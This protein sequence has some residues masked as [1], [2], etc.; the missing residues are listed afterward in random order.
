MQNIEQKE[1]D[2][3]GRVIIDMQV[4][5]DDNFLSVFS[6]KGT[7][8]ISAEVAGF[9]ESSIQT[10]NP[11][12]SLCLRVYSD[13]ID[14][15]EKVVYEKAIRKYYSDCHANAKQ[16]SKTNLII[17]AILA[18]IGIALLAFSII[19]GEIGSAIWMEAVDI[20]AWV[21]CWEAVDVVA[22]KNR[23]LKINSLK[24]K[25]LSEM[26]IEFYSINK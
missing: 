11:K 5:D 21:F 8:V 23:S 10:V 26:Q 25:A 13:C 7:Q 16:G 15:N 9:I 12:E 3:N 18:F 19:V 22:F 6:K 14:D 4:T 20:V 2:S 17:S 24:Y 1:R